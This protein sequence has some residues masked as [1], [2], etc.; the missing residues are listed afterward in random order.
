MLRMVLTMLAGAACVGW[1]GA[2][3]ATMHTTEGGTYV[4]QGGWL[5]TIEHAGLDRAWQATQDAVADLEFTVSEKAKDSLQAR[6]EADQA[7][8]TD[9][10][11]DLQRVDDDST[12]IRIKVGTFGEREVAELVLN[13]IRARIKDPRPASTAAAEGGAEK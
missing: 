10:R 6:L 4:Y 9:V 8:G 7:D 5:E 3:S 13:K 1:L 12:K 11:V 2:C